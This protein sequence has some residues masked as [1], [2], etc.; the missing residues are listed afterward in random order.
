MYKIENKSFV[1][2]RYNIKT[3]ELFLIGG[4]DE[5][6]METYKHFASDKS[7][8]DMNYS[9]TDL[10]TTGKDQYSVNNIY[11]TRK[12]LKPVI[13]LDGYNRIINPRNFLK[14]AMKKYK[15]LQSKEIY[16]QKTYAEIKYGK[17]NYLYRFDPVPGIHKCKSYSNGLKNRG[18]HRLYSLISDPEYGRY[19]RKKAIPPIYNDNRRYRTCE[20]WKKQ[21][22]R[23]QWM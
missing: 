18:I 3:G 17:R 4:I 19:I 14:E 16:H 22:K 20:S 23:K 7:Y 12:E 10:N 6:I 21:K 15:Y 2:Y 1:F 13:Y 8:F 5:M 11:E 9:V